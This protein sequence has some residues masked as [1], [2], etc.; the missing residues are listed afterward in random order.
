MR[1][2]GAIDLEMRDVRPSG[3]GSLPF[4]RH[5]TPH[6]TLFQREAPPSLVLSWAA[7]QPGKC[8]HKTVTLSLDRHLY[9]AATARQQ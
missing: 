2:A 9:A 1:T 3:S 5:A 6:E 4:E 7:V 8:Q